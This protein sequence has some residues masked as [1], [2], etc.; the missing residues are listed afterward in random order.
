VKL[1][2]ARELLDGTPRK[3]M[4]DARKRRIWEAHQGLCMECGEPVPM[5]GRE[6]EYDHEI[7][8]A[9]NGGEDDFNVGPIHASPCH[10]VKTKRDITRIAKAKRQRALVEEIQPSKRPLKSKPSWPPP[11][12]RKLVSRPFPTRRPA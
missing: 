2:L 4:T 1:F 12:S 9:L 10:R 5:T 11:G 8:L 3:S 7:P 6:V